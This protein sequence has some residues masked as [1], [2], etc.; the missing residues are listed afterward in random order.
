MYSDSSLITNSLKSVLTNIVC[1]LTGLTASSPANFRTP[2]PGA[3][4]ITFDLLIL[5]ASPI[6]PI[7]T[8]TNS[9]PFLS[10]SFL[11]RGK[12]ISGFIAKVV[13]FH[14]QCHACWK[15]GRRQDPDNLASESCTIVL[16]RRCSHPGTLSWD[17]A[18]HHLK[19]CDGP[20][21]SRI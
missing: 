8:L 4:T 15:L 6:E 12:R 1:P 17:R 2:T 3:F 10:S 21:A 19:D 18:L 7:S 16:N 13:Y 14:S 9:T 20:G 5:L 11:N